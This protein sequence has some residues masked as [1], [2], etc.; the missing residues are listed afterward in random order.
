VAAG[1][2]ALEFVGGALGDQPAVVEHRDP[3][4]ELI[5]FVEVL[6]GEEDG[7]AVGH[8]SADDVPHRAAAARVKSGRRLVQENDLR[9]GDQRH[10]QVQLPAH[11]AG[12]GRRQL[13]GRLRQ[14]EA[15]KQRD[16]H[17]LGLAR[18][19]VVQVRHQPQVL[20]PR[21]EVVHRRELTGDPDQRAHR[22]RFGPNVMPGDAGCPA[23]GLDQRGQ[24]VHRRGLARPIRAEQGKDRA[25]GNIEVDA[26]E[27]H[28]VPV[29][30]A[31]P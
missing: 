11:A 24:H 4:G 7:D 15:L 13:L 14:V 18:P 6:G 31:Q 19:Q 20:F 25:R 30:L 10:R 16:D 26:V 9:P 17:P 22:L 27:H 21:Q 1:D 28:L 8:Q 12:I 5:G 2:L 23:V 3:G 29:R